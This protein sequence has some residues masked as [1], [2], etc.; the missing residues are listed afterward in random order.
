MPL[1]V[2][3]GE[4]RPVPLPAGVEGGKFIVPIPAAAATGNVLRII[5]RGKPGEGAPAFLTGFQLVAGGEN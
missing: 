3:V 4:Q 2:Q 5:L 1:L